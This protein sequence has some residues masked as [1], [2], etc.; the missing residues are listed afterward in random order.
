MAQQVTVSLS[1]KEELT[2]L[3]THSP[4]SPIKGRCWLDYKLMRFILR[5][6][7]LAMTK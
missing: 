3:F 7:E 1:P 4:V 6:C 5:H 2:G